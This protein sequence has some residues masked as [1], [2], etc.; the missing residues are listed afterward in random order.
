M[1]WKN[2]SKWDTGDAEDVRCDDCSWAEKNLTTKPLVIHPDVM[3]VARQLCNLI[4][5]EWQMLLTGR[6]ETGRVW[7]NGYY[8]PEQETT[9]GTVSNLE[10]I[11]QAKIDE[12]GIVATMHSHNNMGVFFSHT[13]VTDTNCSLIRHHIVV[14]NSG[15]MKAVSRLVLPCGLEKFEDVVVAIHTENADRIEGISKIKEKTYSYYN[16]H[17]PYLPP[18]R[19][20]DDDS[21]IHDKSKSNRKQKRKRALANRDINPDY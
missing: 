17:T 20:Q 6:E 10:C 4:Q 12:L 13:D 5:R 3:A 1:T 21:D 8:I 15:E 7:I 2:D 16:Q 19:Y 14:N 18:Y 9:L 11:D